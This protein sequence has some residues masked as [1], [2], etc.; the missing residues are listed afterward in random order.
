MAFDHREHLV[1]LRRSKSVAP[2]LIADYLKHND[3]NNAEL[4]T[5]AKEAIRHGSSMIIVDEWGG[6]AHQKT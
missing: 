2:K 4:D 1:N 3:G 6:I 5:A